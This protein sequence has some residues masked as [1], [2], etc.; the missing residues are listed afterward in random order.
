VPDKRPARPDL[1]RDDRP[2]SLELEAKP[3]P[4]FKLRDSL[5]PAIAGLRGFFTLRPCAADAPETC[6][7]CQRILVMR[8]EAPAN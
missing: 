2:L 3:V 7:H 6:P 8:Q 5:P 4:F 1:S